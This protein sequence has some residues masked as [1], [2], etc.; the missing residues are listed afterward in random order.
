VGDDK[1]LINKNFGGTFYTKSKILGVKVKILR[2][3]LFTGLP[4]P[5]MI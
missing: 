2:V 4:L 3:I 1:I 5:I